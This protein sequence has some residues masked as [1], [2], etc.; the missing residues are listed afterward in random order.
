MNEATSLYACTHRGCDHLHVHSSWMW[1][2]ARA[3]IL[4]VTACTCTHP[5]LDRLHV[6]SSWMWSPARAY[7]LWVTSCTCTYLVRDRLHVHLP[8]EWP[9][10][11]AR[12]PSVT[13][14][15]CT[16][17]R[18]DRLD[19]DLVSPDNP[20]SL[21]LTRGAPL[22]LDAGAVE[23]F[24]L[25]PARLA[26]HC[27]EQSAHTMKHRASPGA[28]RSLLS[29][30][31]NNLQPICKNVFKNN[32]DVIGINGV[33]CGCIKNINK[34]LLVRNMWR[35]KT[36]ICFFWG[37]GTVILL[38]ELF[39]VLCNSTPT[40]IC[41]VQIKFKWTDYLYVLYYTIMQC[42]SWWL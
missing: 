11:R 28:T 29:C 36:K 26:R 23:H 25:H 37:G 39:N 5:V 32:V 24:H 34:R 3:L 38:R 10:T 41:R 30:P 17:P 35:Q 16:H 22:D 12:I 14:C 27:P 42:V 6:H 19:V 9:H 33:V 7:T 4:Y 31:A 40:Y 13:A 15:T 2:H 18:R 1:P 8:Y 21:S 20:I